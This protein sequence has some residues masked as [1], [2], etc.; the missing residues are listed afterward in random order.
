MLKGSS[1]PPLK[2]DLIGESPQRQGA[3]RIVGASTL[4]WL[5]VSELTPYAVETRYDAEFWPDRDM[6]DAAV[7]CSDRVAD[8][9]SS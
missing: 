4:G 6:A 9:I 2:P 8:L 1:V 7:A 3:V 5:D